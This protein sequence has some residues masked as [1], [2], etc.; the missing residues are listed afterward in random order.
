MISPQRDTRVA[1]FRTEA[2]RSVAVRLAAER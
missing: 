1:G 2:G